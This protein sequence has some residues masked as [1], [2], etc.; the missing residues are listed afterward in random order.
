MHSFENANQA[1]IGM[2]R[3]IL[4]EGKWRNVRGLKCLE[5]PHPVMVEI[6]NPTDRYIT[7]PTR[8]WNRFLP[9]VE[10]LWLA[11]GLND[12]DA[13]PG[14]YV[15][16]LY[17][18][19]DD[20]R[21]WRAGYGPRLRAFTGNDADYFIDQPTHRHIFTG[22]TTVVD[23]LKYVIDSFGR[24]MGT[25]QAI[26][27]LGD[28]AKDCFDPQG[29]LKVTKDFPCSRSVQFMIVDGKLNCTLYIRSND[30]VFGFSGVNIFNFTWM[31]E[32]IANI[33]GVP[34]G[35]YYHVANNLHVY[36][37][38]MSKVEDY[39]TYDLEDYRSPYPVFQYSDLISG[40]TEFDAQ[41]IQLYEYEAYLRNTPESRLL[42]SFGNDM[43]DDW[44]RVF[45]QYK[46]PDKEL[47]F[48][49]P[50]LSKLFNH[51]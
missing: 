11:L 23:Q 48:I 9:F 45:H 19:S 20:G 49:N 26:I 28:P 46:F 31:Q 35:K 6:T 22:R 15:K 2:S 10:S 30:I 27:T 7:L 51:V 37:D 29:E 18:Y 21:T 40:L 42:R 34:I 8:K 44:S 39:A 50:Y 16:N 3:L 41:L 36:A 1:L 47:N 24:D 25:R 12:L 43:F 5:I 17:K 33:I 4:F 14:H 32:Y 38:F 13:F